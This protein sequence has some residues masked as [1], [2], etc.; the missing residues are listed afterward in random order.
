MPNL[1][2]KSLRE[3]LRIIGDYNKQIDVS[4]SGV[5]REQFPKAG[6]KLDK[7]KKISLN[8]SSS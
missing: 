1:V 6:E 2:G 7:I 5:V 3:A 4:G 8:C